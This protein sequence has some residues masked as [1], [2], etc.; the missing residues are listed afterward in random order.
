MWQA[1]PEEIRLRVA[2]CCVGVVVRNGRCI[3]RHQVL[4]ERAPS[5]LPPFNA[6]VKPT[7]TLNAFGY[8]IGYVYARPDATFYYGHVYVQDLGGE[9]WRFY[10]RTNNYRSKQAAQWLLSTATNTWYHLR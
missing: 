3:G 2:L 10:W 1:L 5:F 6:L 8:R 7:C 4:W 9:E